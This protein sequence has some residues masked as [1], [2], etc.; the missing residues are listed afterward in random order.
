MMPFILDS[1]VFR[2]S[3]FKTLITESDYIYLDCFYG[4]LPQNKLRVMTEYAFPFL[5]FS[6]TAL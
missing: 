2:Q 6:L 5:V 1:H 4:Y 3:A